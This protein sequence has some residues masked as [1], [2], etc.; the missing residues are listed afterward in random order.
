ME[1]MSIVLVGV[2]G[3]GILFTTRALAQTATR[4]GYDVI[5]TETHGMS[6]R[7]GSVVSHIKIG[8]SGP[9]VRRGTADVLLALE[10]RE[11]ARSLDYLRDGGLCVAN[12]P[13]GTF[14]DP[15]LQA[16]LD[17]RAL[18]CTSID[19]DAIALELGAPPVANTT[20][21]GFAAARPDML[22]TLEQVSESITRLSS[23]ALRAVNMEAFQRGAEVA[24]AQIIEGG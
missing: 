15:A 9:L 5:G 14:P 22:F 13:E 10:A 23:A 11:A 17:D 19:A 3:Q 16:Y 24:Q 20:L 4:L 6:Q 12:A 18:I 7:G 2:G 8:G 1:G 21:L